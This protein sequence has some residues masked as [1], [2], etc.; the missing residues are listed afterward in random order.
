MPAKSHALYV[1]DENGNPVWLALPTDPAV[2]PSLA[3]A[4][5]TMLADFEAAVANGDIAWWN[6]AGGPWVID[7]LTTSFGGQWHVNVGDADQD[8]LPDDLDP[9]PTDA[10]NHSFYWQGGTFTIHGIR[11]TFRA[12]NY[13]GT[14][15][16]TNGNDLPDSLEDWFSNPGAHGT[17]QHWEGGTFLINGEYS[18]FAGFSYYADDATDS[19]G[20]GIPDAFDPYPSDIWNHTYFVWN[21]TQYGGVW[22]DRDG[23]GIPDQADAWPDDSSNGYTSDTTTTE[24]TFDPN[25]DDDGDGLPNGLEVQYPGVLDPHN[26]ADASYDRSDGITYLQAYQQGLPLILPPPT[27]PT[28]DPAS[29]TPA[30]DPNADDDG[31]GIPNAVELQY[32][33]ILDPANGADATADRG[34]GVSYLQAYQQGWPL[35]LPPPDESTTTAPDPNADDDGDGIPNG[36]EWQYPGLLDASVYDSGTDRGDGLTYLQAYQLGL[37]LN[38]LDN[39]SDGMSDAYEITNGL[40]ALDANDAMQSANNDDIF[41]IE[42]ARLGVP[43]T[44][45]ITAEQLAS[46]HPP[47]TTDESPPVDN[48]TSTDDSSTSETATTETPPANDS[49]QSPPTPELTDD[50]NLSLAENDW[51]GDGISNQDEVMVFGTDPRDANSKPSDADI[52]AAYGNNQ[53]SATT[54][55]NAQPGPEAP[56]SGDQDST[57]NGNDPSDTDGSLGPIGGSALGPAAGNVPPIEKTVISVKTK[58]SV[59]WRVIAD[60]TE[61]AFIATKDS[62]ESLYHYQHFVSWGAF[63]EIVVE[64]TFS[65]G[66]VKITTIEADEPLPF[67]SSDHGDGTLEPDY[68]KSTVEEGFKTFPAGASPPSSNTPSSAE[69]TP[70]DPADLPSS[71]IT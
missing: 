3:D 21:G 33:G 10:T 8:G 58:S 20:D 31:D 60:H 4:A 16:D 38:S 19:D 55:M 1:P 37:V 62:G 18:T 14:V 69:P 59:A 71:P 49:P 34:D 50:P 42:K 6:A 44:A 68:F 46:L 51:D 29:T 63:P 47:T 13:A 70:P 64:T 40:N 52:A 12:D 15:V 7:G 25:A 41:N 66:S 57:P 11:H 22:A 36:V 56:G 30:N 61:W 2:A 43:V 67:G 9:Y 24:P 32:P 28:I 54:L 26:A 39:D 27:E 35:V 53:L 5:P 48:N 23:D 65:D 45:T 17:L